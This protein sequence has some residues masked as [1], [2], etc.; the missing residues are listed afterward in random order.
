MSTELLRYW[1]CPPVRSVRCLDHPREDGD[2]GQSPDLAS[3]NPCGPSLFPVRP[4]SGSKEK[5]G[6]S[7]TQGKLPCL[8]SKGFLMGSPG[9]PSAEGRGGHQLWKTNWS[10]E[11][12]LFRLPANSSKQ[13]KNQIYM[14]NSRIARLAQSQLWEEGRVQTS[15]SILWTSFLTNLMGRTAY[16]ISILVFWEYTFALDQSTLRGHVSFM[17]FPELY[18]SWRNR[19]WITQ[20]NIQLSWKAAVLRLW[21]GGVLNI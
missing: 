5:Q 6:L 13:I 21:T 19:V 1:P 20:S 8:L 14:R 2:W 10:T 12:F 11:R 4:L 17:V 18:G 9:W 3:R 15:S 7:S 16:W